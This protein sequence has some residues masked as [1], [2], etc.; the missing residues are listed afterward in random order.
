M[1]ERR[2]LSILL[3][4]SV[5]VDD[6]GVVRVLF[7]VG[8]RVVVGNLSLDDLLVFRSRL[9]HLRVAPCIFLHLFTSQKTHWKVLTGRNI[10][11]AAI[12]TV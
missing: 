10:R 3:V 2:C 9:F 6:V 4:P 12:L 7:T 5:R 1:V 8:G 11:Q